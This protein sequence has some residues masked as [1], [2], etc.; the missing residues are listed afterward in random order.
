MHG[1]ITEG[2][3]TRTRRSETVN[4]PMLRAEP[5]ERAARLESSSFAARVIASAFSAAPFRFRAALFG[6]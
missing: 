2:D 1:W 6:R 3:E 5:E 4:H